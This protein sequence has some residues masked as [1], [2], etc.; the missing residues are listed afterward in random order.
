MRK[1][2]LGLLLAVAAITA[3]A[4]SPSGT[5]DACAAT[6]PAAPMGLPW[7]VVL[8]TNCGRFTVDTDGRV[9]VQPGASRPVPAGA[10]W[11]PIDGRWWKVDRGHLLVGTWHETLWRLHGTFRS[12]F[13]VGGLVF[14]QNVVAFSYG[15]GPHEKLFVAPL[16]GRE[17]LV[18]TGE[19]PLA[20]TATGRLLT[21][22]S[23]GGRIYARQTAGSGRR[24]LADHVS[25]LAT[26]PD[27]TLFFLERDRLL[28]TNGSRPALLAR[29]SELGLTGPPA[30]E[31][32]GPL[33]ALLD[34]HR[35]V[36]LRADGSPFASTQLPRR[37]K[38]TDG[39]SSA[40][41]TD[42]EAD[43]VAFTATNGNTA[44]GSTGTETTYL[45]RAGDTAAT[46][47][48]NERIDFAVC[49]RIAE[50]DWHQRWLLYSASEGNVAAVD[51]NG[52]SPTVNLS[53]FARALPGTE[54]DD[55]EGGLDIEASWAVRADVSSGS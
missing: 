36:V 25:T 21:L 18:A 19:A 15:Y 24:P 9:A 6:L 44:L 20:F 11:S 1:L 16:D 4:A 5:A 14:A 30:L 45:L 46:A 13:E 28:S 7:P 33:V 55:S 27:G 35:L 2:A 40:V 41:T 17:H 51:T 42:A 37:K 47:I 12:A 48:H 49:E 39:V 54:D 34:R 52:V 29:V 50:L 43:A 23:R 8:Q 26:A 53:A 32:P 3:S 10:A 38:R 31:A 22:G